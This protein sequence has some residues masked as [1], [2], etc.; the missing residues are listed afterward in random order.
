MWPVDLRRRRD[1]Q[2]RS[3]HRPKAT[4]AGPRTALPANWKTRLP[5][6]ADYY[7]KHVPGLRRTEGWAQGHCPFHDDQRASFSVR[8]SVDGT[9]VWKCFAGCGV[10]DLVAFHMRRTGLGFV[11]AVQ[12][13][14]GGRADER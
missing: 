10:G 2:V 14:I 9:G 3:R 5:A 4:K 8:L 7:A 1:I 13:L 11:E 12:D 6:P